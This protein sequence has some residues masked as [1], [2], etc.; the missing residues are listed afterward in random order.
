MHFSADSAYTVTPLAH[1]FAEAM[2]HVASQGD[3]RWEANQAP[4]VL[5]KAF[6]PFGLAEGNRSP[7]TT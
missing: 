1:R 5:R 7:S 2:N 6:A 3:D 4:S